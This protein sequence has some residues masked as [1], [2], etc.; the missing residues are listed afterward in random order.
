MANAFD[1][2]EADDT[3]SLP[4]SRTRSLR[5]SPR[6]T[7]NLYLNTSLE[8]RFPI[9]P[10]VVEPESE[11]SDE[12][13]YSLR[14]LLPAMSNPN[15]PPARDIRSYSPSRALARRSPAQ[16]DEDTAGDKLR[17]HYRTEQALRCA[18]DTALQQFQTARPVNF[19][20][21]QARLLNAQAVS[22]G[23]V[24]T[25][26]ILTWFTK[27]STTF[28]QVLA[29]LQ[30]YLREEAYLRHQLASLEQRGL[31]NWTSD[32]DYSVVRHASARYGSES[33][34]IGIEKLTLLFEGQGRLFLRY[35]QACLDVR[36]VRVEQATAEDRY[37]KKMWEQSVDKKVVGW[38]A[39]AE[40]YLARRMEAA[41]PA[42]AKEAFGLTE[43]ADEDSVYHNLVSDLIAYR[44]KLEARQ[45][46]IEILMESRKDCAG[47]SQQLLQMAA[48]D[49]NLEKKVRMRTALRGEQD[50]TAKLV[51][52]MV[53]NFG[54][55]VLWDWV[56]D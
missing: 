48:D 31:D 50:R 53:K 33:Q 25:I 40:K 55:R 43:Y 2:V 35:L 39:A 22:Q 1:A 44:E 18:F 21:F 32:H 24:R 8:E 56:D 27:V 51:E 29:R 7:P 10:P 15:P 20:A 14:D 13:A 34:A 16:H 23:E 46:N 5:S 26:D 36:M 45:F 47:L 4:A 42:G 49:E 9:V 3:S 11:S 28:H 17:E 54:A 30:T 6:R 41:Q 37:G 52:Q 12:E 38:I 19:A